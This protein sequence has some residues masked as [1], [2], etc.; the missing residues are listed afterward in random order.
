M[1]NDNS[2]GRVLQFVWGTEMIDVTN[3][4]GYRLSL[5]SWQP[6]V[7]QRSPSMLGGKSP[8]SPV[9]EQ[10]PLQIRAESPDG[11]T[12]AINKLNRMLEAADIFYQYETGTPVVMY[13]RT[14]DAWDKQP[15]AC[16]VRRSMGPV[17]LPSNF[18]SMMEGDYRTKGY[19]AV[20]VVLRFERDGLWLYQ[21]EAQTSASASSY[22]QNIYTFNFANDIAQHSSPAQYVLQIVT[23]STVSPVGYFVLQSAGYFE[24]KT[25]P[26]AGTYVATAETGSTSGNVFRVSA[27]GKLNWGLTG[28]STN[29]NHHIFVKLR[30]NSGSWRIR[31]VDYAYS[32]Q[33]NTPYMT[34]TGTS[35]QILYL[36]LFRRD[37]MGSIGVQYIMD[38]AGTLDID[39]V[40]VVGVD[41]DTNVVGF[42]TTQTASS[43]P[44]TT[45]GAA[46]LTRLS[47]FINLAS[48]D[49]A[50]V[51][52]DL[53]LNVSGNAHKVLPYLVA[54]TRMNPHTG[55]VFLT[56]I[57][58]LYRWVGQPGAN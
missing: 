11:I 50:S 16:L 54:G 58:I 19:L 3:D 40:L 43:T 32:D 26:S 45:V 46:P 13:F 44:I 51:S 15:L 21:S 12:R 6:K 39:S 55:A 53:F 23:N 49:V 48:W 38:S 31:A 37:N 34:I 36:G 9:E 2:Y 33:F 42:S 30:A 4:Y 52:G 41:H 7:A 10:I 27:S 47:P 35:P 8:Y 1:S 24:L 17:T 22:F 18:I 56:A 20:D 57:Q 25:T 5:D 14:G 29:I 28:T